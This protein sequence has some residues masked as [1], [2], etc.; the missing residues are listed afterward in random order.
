MHNLGYILLTQ[1]LAKEFHSSFDNPFHR[2]WDLP[3]FLPLFCISIYKQIEPSCCVLLDA[4]VRLSLPLLLSALIYELLYSHRNQQTCL[5]FTC[6]KYHFPFPAFICLE[7]YHTVHT[8]SVS[9]YCCYQSVT[10]SSSLLRGQPIKLVQGVSTSEFRE[11]CLKD[12][13]SVKIIPSH[14]CKEA[15]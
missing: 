14:F 8:L 4:L 2:G 13:V 7:S 5:F 1:L 9:V 3:V 11:F 10:Q 6:I 15:S 12:L